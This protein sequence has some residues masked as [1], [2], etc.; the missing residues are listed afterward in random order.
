MSRTVPKTQPLQ[1]AISLLERVDSRSQNGDFGEEN[2]LGKGGVDRG[3]K[4]KGCAKKGGLF[5]T[6][7]L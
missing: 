3:K 5:E 1:V 2:C 7:D 6:S 4:E